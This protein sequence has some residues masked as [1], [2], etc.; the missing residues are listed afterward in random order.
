LN[1]AASN[2]G[3]QA[4]SGRLSEKSASKADRWGYFDVLCER[5][6]CL[7]RRV[8]GFT[9]K[10]EDGTLARR[11]QPLIADSDLFFQ[12]RNSVSPLNSL[13]KL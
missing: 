6:E 13:R 8:T 4:A 12:R 1:F 9:S 3:R 7:L 2:T 11:L 10:K 5:N